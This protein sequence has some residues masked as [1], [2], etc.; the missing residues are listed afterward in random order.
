MIGAFGEGEN[1]YNPGDT[2]YRPAAYDAALVGDAVMELTPLE[3]KDVATV[4]QD[5]ATLVDTFWSQ[6]K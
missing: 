2:S 6:S 5:V 1:A 4:G 3:T